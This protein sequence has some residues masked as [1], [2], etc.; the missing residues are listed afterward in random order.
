MLRVTL[1]FLTHCFPKCRTFAIRVKAKCEMLSPVRHTD[2]VY[3]CDCMVLVPQNKIIYPPVVFVSFLHAK[4]EQV[5]YNAALLSRP[6]QR[7]SILHDDEYR[8]C[9]YVCVAV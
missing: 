5:V 9:V 7:D 8:S 1:G 2:N 6:V 4:K 3:V